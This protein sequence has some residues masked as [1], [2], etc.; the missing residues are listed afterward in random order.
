MASK[1]NQKATTNTTNLP[2]LR[3]GSHVRCTDDGVEGRIVRANGLMVTIEWTDGEKVTW[4]RDSLAN[5][6]IEILDDETAPAS[7]PKTEE[8]T[9]E[10]EAEQP[11][12]TTAAAETTVHEQSN[13]QEE[14]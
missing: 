13:A 1:K 2:S 6:P 3:I 7:E 8:P 14:S 9:A 5:K 4:R 11:A 10:P 12:V